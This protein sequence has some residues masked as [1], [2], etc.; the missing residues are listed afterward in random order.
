M[1]KFARANNTVEN[2]YCIDFVNKDIKISQ[3]PLITV[4]FWF[5]FSL[6]GDVV[7]YGFFIGIIF[8][9]SFPIIFII[10]LSLIFILCL[11][12]HLG[13]TFSNKKIWR[14][15]M[16]YLEYPSHR[17]FFRKGQ[18]E[19][20]L[21]GEKTISIY[22]DFIWKYHALF[23]G[24]CKNKIKQIKYY[25]NKKIFRVNQEKIFIEFIEP[26][27]GRIDLNYYGKIKDII[28]KR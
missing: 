27:Y 19:I 11:I 28:L 8:L 20:I 22:G 6:F 9:S 26:A 4:F 5:I 3:K 25:K 18:K 13:Y 24:E 14:D 10:Y 21:K 15:M 16:M 17:I 1:L 23:Y 7:I 2:D 12:I